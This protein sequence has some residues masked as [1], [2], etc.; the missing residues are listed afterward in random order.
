M[1]DSE[2]EVQEQLRMKLSEILKQKAGTEI[3]VAA[4]IG[5]SPALLASQ[6]LP[7]S[8]ARCYWNFH[9][10]VGCDEPPPD[11]A[12]VPLRAVREDFMECF[13]FWPTAPHP[14]LNVPQYQH[15]KEH[16]CSETATVNEIEFCLF[17]LAAEE[18]DINTPA[19]QDKFPPAGYVSLAGI[20]WEEDDFT[21]PW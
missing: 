21:N 7:L 10:K 16:A 14:A 19:D 2:P 20:P 13:G 9:K 3:P 8:F 18:D 4:G 12:T 5:S 17:S 1:G 11:D 15:T 6:L